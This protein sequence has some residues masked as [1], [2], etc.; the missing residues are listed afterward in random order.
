MTLIPTLKQRLAQPADVV[1]SGGISDLAGIS[2]DGDTVTIGAMTTHA[3]VAASADVKRKIPHL[4]T[5]Q[6]VSVIHR[7]ATEEPSVA[8]LPIMIRPLTTLPLVLGWGPL[9]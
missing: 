9:S 2:V 5:L 7:S 8:P 3:T 4:P 1:D 6:T